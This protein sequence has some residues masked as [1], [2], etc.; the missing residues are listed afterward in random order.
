MNKTKRLQ[1]ECQHCGGSLEFPAES[2]G[3]TAE[4][5]HCA[6]VTELML[7]TPPQEPMIPRKVLVW[8]LVTV[9]VLIAG[10]VFVLVELNRYAKR[11]AERQQKATASAHSE[12]NPP[13][14][15]GPKP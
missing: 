6:K 1:G 2:I 4:C 8:T 15:K 12:T 9:A 3:L 5:P 11:V 7:A 13:V 10:F 14:Q